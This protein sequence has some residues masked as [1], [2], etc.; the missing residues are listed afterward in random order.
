MFVTTAT[1]GPSNRNERSLSSASATRQL[2]PRP[3]ARGCR[4]CEPSAN[5][6]R[7]VQPRAVEHQPHHR[8][9]GRLAVRAGDRDAC[10]GAIRSAR[11]C[12]RTTGIPRRSAS[13]TSGFV[14]RTAEEQDHGVRLAHVP[15]RAPGRTRAPSDSR[16]A[17][18][19]DRLHVRSAHRSPARSR[20]SASGL[21]PLPPTPTKCTARRVRPEQRAAPS[22]RRV[23]RR[24]PPRPPP[25]QPDR[26]SPSRRPARAAAHRR[27]PR[28]AASPRAQHRAGE[29]LASELALFDHLRAAGRASTS[30]VLP[31]VVVGRRRQRDEHR[32]SSRRR[33]LGQRAGPG[34]ARP[35]DRRAH[36]PVA[37]RRGTARPEPQPG[38]LRNPPG[39]GPDRV[40][41]SGG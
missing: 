2:A 12:P 7:R 34:A 14:V 38:A 5:H 41:R 4:K 20:I 18:T 31:L 25:A 22:E 27:H 33:Q 3:P 29:P 1:C 40:P 9:G 39:P 11:S 16:C 23:A 24:R 37:S 10:R 19:A 17:V 15:A 26:Q 30:R 36:L 28:R 6:H 8:G 13:A 21:I 32:G 35:P